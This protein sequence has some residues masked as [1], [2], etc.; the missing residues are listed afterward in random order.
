MKNKISTVC[1]YTPIELLSGFG[2]EAE[3]LDPQPQAFACSDSCAHPNLC[4]YG[5]AVL[6]EVLAGKVRSLFLVDCCDVCRRLF[7][8][9]SA[10]A[11][12]DF[13]FLMYL[14]H[15]NSE[16]EIKIFAQELRRLNIYLESRT[17]KTFNEAAARKAWRRGIEA[18][19]KS[20]LRESHITL[21]GA[22]GGCGLKT[23]MEKITGLPVED[24][25]CTGNRELAHETGGD[26][27]TDYAAALLSQKS[28]C[29]RMQG[30]RG[31]QSESLGTVCHTIKF[32]DY[33]GFQYKELQ[34]QKGALLKIETDYTAQS[35]GQI[36][37]RLEAFA[38]VI[39]RDNALAGVHGAAGNGIHGATQA[40]TKKQ[41]EQR[42]VCGIDSG[43]SSTDAVILDERK[44]IVGFSILSTGS[45]AGKS[46]KEALEEAL[47][48]AGLTEKDI[49]ATV[50]TGYGRNN[51]QA[52][53]SSITEI[54]CHAK[55][56]VHLYPK[57]R[58]VID[59]GGQDS[60]VIVLDERGSVINFVMNDKCA[61]GTGRFLETMAKVLGLS[62]AE[63]SR[64]SLNRKRV[65]SISSTC[66]VFAE[67]EVVS[68]VA[69]NTPVADIVNGLNQAVASKTV[70]LVKRAKGMPPYIMTG[71]VSNNLGLVKTLEE[72]LGE[73]IFVPKEA[74]VCG[75]LGAALFA[76]E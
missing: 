17:G 3:R 22:H 42:F 50:T 45:G 60:K 69:H 73:K 13:L 54:S 49:C 55:G 56:A 12:M 1:K 68:L 41:K 27:F 39:H 25:T 75:A 15:K 4:G 9:I 36:K 5:K 2:L 7:D 31:E 30:E 52:S 35:D 46:G 48:M 33:Y 21:V 53:S 47:Q 71:G 16:S 63:M 28:P 76:L 38:E 40:E 43:S 8:I 61:A 26:F 10:K 24:A 67:S 57:A 6:E 23:Q 72:M 58:T 59:I 66:T 74:Q 37:T 14:P 29:M 64:L 19:K 70:S 65:V 44:K 32:C 62:L 51:L 34:E 20:R 11:D 18:A